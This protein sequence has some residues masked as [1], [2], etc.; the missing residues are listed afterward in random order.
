MQN[1]VS[2]DGP[3]VVVLIRT[4]ARANDSTF[5]RSSDEQSFG[6]AVGVNGGPRSHISFG[7]AT[8]RSGCN[9]RVRAERYVTPFG[10]CANRTFAVE[11]NNKIGHFRADLWSPPGATCPDERRP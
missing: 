8:D 2:R 6:P 9:T 5:Q 1:I 4:G 3:A 11:D 7:S 10:K